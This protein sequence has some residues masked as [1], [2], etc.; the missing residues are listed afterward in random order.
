MRKVKISFILVVMLVLS[1]VTLC[2][3]ATKSD[4]K[5]VYNTHTL[6]FGDK[7]VVSQDGSIYIPLRA[8]SEKL[9]YTVDWIA[10]TNTARIHDNFDDI[11]LSTN[12]DLKANGVEGKSDK[13][14]ILVNGS[15][16][17]P[18]RF[19]SETLGVTVN[20]D[21]PNRAVKMTGPTIYEISQKDVFKPQLV[22]FTREGKKITLDLGDKTGD[23]TLD[24][25]S[26]YNKTNIR[27]VERTEYSD[28][29]TTEYT[30]SGALTVNE[31]KQVYI[32]G[33][34]IIEYADLDT[35]SFDP[36]TEI[37]KPTL[38]FDNRVAFLEDGEKGN[39]VKIYDDI[40]GKLITEF[41]AIDTFNSYFSDISKSEYN[42]QIY[43]IQAVGEDFLVVNMYQP[44]SFLKVDDYINSNYHATVIN[45]DTMDITPVY[46]HLDDFKNNNVMLDGSYNNFVGFGS[47][48]SDGVYFTSRTNDGKLKFV[49][50]YGNYN[51]GRATDSCLVEYK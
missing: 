20:Y 43:N 36:N 39:I 32:H 25:M 38:Y 9:H 4:I 17:V 5:V 28:I 33:D 31:R 45:L 15:I 51:T 6:D 16:Y 27:T 35:Y 41:N 30:Y 37:I 34:N 24:T 2:Y 40:T 29:V 14:P 44:N 11:Y 8:L 21:S 10:K 13:V 47:V 26:D 12:G 18:L 3:G 19:V 7:S 48:A 50:R 23:F 42:G 1:T 22:G 46:E 49:A